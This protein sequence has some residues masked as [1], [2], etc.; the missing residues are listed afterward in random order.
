MRQHRQSF[1]AANL[2]ERK[3]PL[4]TRRK[5]AR[6]V[7]LQSSETPVSDRLFEQFDAFLTAPRIDTR[8]SYK[9]I[10]AVDDLL[11]FEVKLFNRERQVFVDDAEVD[12]QQDRQIDSRQV[13]FLQQ[14]CTLRILIQFAQQS[15]DP[16]LLP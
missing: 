5:P 1:L 11:V 12:D 4:V 7:D 3:H 9:P 10:G 13:H 16:L 14:L 6:R 15:F 8:E 2:V